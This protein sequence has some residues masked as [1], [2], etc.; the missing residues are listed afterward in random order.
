MITTR[1]FAVLG[2]FLVMAMGLFGNQVGRAVKKGREFDRYLTVR[3]LSER[4][5]KANLAIW[6]IQFSVLAEDLSTLKSSMERDRSLVLT[7]L[8]DQ[9]I[10]SDEI[11]IGIPS[12]SDRVDQKLQTE[13]KAMMRFKGTTS[14]VV[15]SSN[16]DQIKSAIQKADGLLER[17]VSLA[18]ADTGDRTQFLFTEVNATKPDMI[19]EATANA[20]HAAEKFAQDSNTKVGAI[21]RAVQGVLEIEDRDTASPERKLLRV[22]TTVDFFVE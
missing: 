11:S 17:G 14:L 16:V 7:Y 6:P 5:V 3:G 18:N 13:S 4:E 22:V 10:K 19:R 21:R 1:S 2:V 9:G 20:R 12:V 8:K 15:R